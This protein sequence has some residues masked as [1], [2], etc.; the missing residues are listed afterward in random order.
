VLLRW[1]SLL[2]RHRLAVVPLSVR[3][4]VVDEELGALRQAVLV[5]LPVELLERHRHQR[6]GISVVEVLREDRIDKLRAI[7]TGVEQGVED[8]FLATDRDAGGMLNLADA[9]FRL[10]EEKLRALV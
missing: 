7:D 8:E 1:I 4:L 6:D 5:L 10:V 3:A 2:E 9:A